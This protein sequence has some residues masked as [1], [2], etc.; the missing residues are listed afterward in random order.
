MSKDFSDPLPPTSD[1]SPP[2]ESLISLHQ[3]VKDYKNMRALNGISVEILPGIT[4][5]LGPNEQGNRH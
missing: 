4:G 2:V 5:L 3:L 1:A